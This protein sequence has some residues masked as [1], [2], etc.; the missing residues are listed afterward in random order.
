M[1]GL[2][3]A[4]LGAAQAANVGPEHFTAFAVDVSNTARPG[5]NTTTV[6][7][8]VNRW[9]SDADRDR[10]VKILQEKGQDALLD[11]LQ[12]MPV[13]GYITTP[14]S[15]RYDLHFARQRSEAE[16]GRTI[17]LATDRYIGTWEALHRP[18]TIDY[19]FTLIQLQL[20]RNSEGIGKVSVAT[21]ITAKKQTIELENF[22]SEPVR[23]TEVKKVGGTH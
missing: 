8:V 5:R 4:D 13:V 15:L 22:S 2:G 12:D 6:D 20:D 10:L 23:L 18:R 17:V 1:L 14:G 21:K 7:I 3:P 9:S 11:A 16:G 19:P